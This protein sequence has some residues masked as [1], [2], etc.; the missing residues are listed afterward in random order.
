V[1]LIAYALFFVTYE[2]FEGGFYGLRF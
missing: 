2:R 1:N